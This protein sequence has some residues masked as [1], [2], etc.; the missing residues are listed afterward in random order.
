MSRLKRCVHGGDVYGA[1]RELA[2][3]PDEFV[4]FSASIN[5]LGPSPRVWKAMSASRHL[6]R[7]YPDPDCWDLRQALATSWQVDPEQVVIGNGSMELIDVLPRALGIHR[8]LVVHPTFSEYAAAME[9]AG[10][11]VVAL[12][13]DRRDQYA[14]PIDRLCRVMKGRHSGGSIDGIVVCHPN[15]PTG[16]A[17]SV[18]D[19]ARVAILARRQ[20]LWLVID[21][22]FADYCPERSVLPDAASWPYVIVLRSMTKFYAL[23]GLRVGYAVGTG[24]AVR[25]LRQ[26]LPPWSINVLGQVAALA[27][28]NDAVYVRKSL[29]FMARERE[30]FRTLLAALPDCVVMPTYANYFLLELPY[31]WHARKVAEQL[32]R[33]G[34]LIRDCS[35]VP[36]LN[37]RSIRFAIRTAQD[38][39]RLMQAFS[40][41]LLDGSSR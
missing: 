6:M 2:C 11:E 32:R 15:S 40:R 39:D 25:R 20:R 5:P 17:C 12:Y 19:L 29:E 35:S 21:E 1:A 18:D 13:A 27:A 38:N 22:A 37:S 31:G 33:I 3:A 24:P 14:I 34:L 28:L 8:L 9:R 4:D 26:L 30:R 36:G 23:P 10:G 41:L 16:Q 7:H